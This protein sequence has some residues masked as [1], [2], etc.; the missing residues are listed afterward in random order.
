M[1]DRLRNVTTGLYLISA[2]CGLVDAV[3]FLALGRVFAEM[4]TG[5]LLLLAFSIGK[6]ELLAG[7]AQYLPAIVAFTLGALVGGRILR[8]PRKMRERRVGF[9]I[10]WVLLWAAAAL[11]AFARP[12]AGNAEG[13]ALIALLSFAMGI[14]NAMIRVHGVPDLATNVMTLTYTGIVA[15]SAFAGGDNTNWRR[16]ALSIGLFC[17]SAAVGA[18]LLSFGLVWPLLLACLVFSVAMLPLMFGESEAR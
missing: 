16:R 17:L 14:Q 8:G 1:P 3:C 18:Y 7:S 11:A 5:N 15:D 4:M 6:G 10:E 13:V 2:I 12:E 9:A